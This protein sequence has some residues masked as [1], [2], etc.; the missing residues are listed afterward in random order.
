MKKKSF[1]TL[2][3]SLV[4]CFGLCINCFGAEAGISAEE[5]KILDRL[6]SAKVNEITLPQSYINEAKNYLAQNDLSAEAVK[7]VLASI[8]TVEATIKETGA[9][10]TAE[11]KEALKKDTAL[12]DKLAAQVVEAGKKAGA[13]LT[14]SFKDGAAKIA[15]KDSTGTTTAQGGSVIKKT[16]FGFGQSAVAVL[17]VVAILGG[18]AVVARKNS[19]ASHEA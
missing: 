12:A 9:T 6:T 10:T 18:C 19:L 1:I 2:V 15:V 3:L 16:G 5:Q 11:L 14:V 13:T 7:D 4:M 17:A 8:D